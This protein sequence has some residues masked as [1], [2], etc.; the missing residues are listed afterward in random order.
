MAFPWS[1]YPL[2]ALATA[3]TLAILGTSAQADVLRVSERFERKRVNIDEEVAKTVDCPKGTTLTG[4]GYALYNLPADR[5]DFKVTASYPFQDGWRVEI[6]NTSGKPQPL[7]MRLYAL[8]L[9]TE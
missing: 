9:S 4:G 1:K 6:R 2:R 7:A 8:C 3:T 5:I